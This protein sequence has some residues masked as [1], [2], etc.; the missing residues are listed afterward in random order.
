MAYLAVIIVEWRSCL[1]LLVHAPGARRLARLVEHAEPKLRE[2]LLSAVEL[3]DP[4]SDAAFDSEQ[5]RA[6]VQSDVAHRMEG[7][8]V[9]RLL[10]VNLVRRYL[11]VAA[12]IVVA[13]VVGF[14]VT[15]LQFGTLLILC[16]GVSGISVGL[17]ARFPDMR[18]T[19]PSK[20]AAGFGGT[21]NL[22]ASLLFIFVVLGI[23]ARLAGFSILKFIRYIR[24]ELLIVLGTSS[25]ES[26]LPRMIEKMEKLGC[27]KSVV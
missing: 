5:F 17:G 12:A 25:S 23:I 27:S 20:I 7:L 26:V 2:D 1:R 11:A 13:L 10:P 24:E 19:D 21:L 16:F 6:L 4:G 3:G 9:E 15:G 14:A 22:V 18:E 8:E